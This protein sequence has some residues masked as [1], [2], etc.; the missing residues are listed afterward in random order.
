[1]RAAQGR[2][3]EVPHCLT[4]E[5]L[6]LREADARSGVFPTKASHLEN[7]REEKVSWLQRAPKVLDGFCEAES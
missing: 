7:I 1:M 6:P 5:S 3:F 2:V 4:S